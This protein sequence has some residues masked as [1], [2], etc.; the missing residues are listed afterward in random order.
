[1]TFTW[2]GLDG[3]PQTAKATP[4][5]RS[6][7]VSFD[8]WKVNGT[9]VTNFD[10]QL[11]IT[12]D[13]C[14]F[15]LVFTETFV[16]FTYKV[17]DVNHPHASISPHSQDAN[18]NE[19][20]YGFTESFRLE[21]IEKHGAAPTGAIANAKTIRYNEKYNYIYEF[22]NWSKEGTSVIYDTADFTPN[23][24]TEGITDWK[25]SATYICH[26]AA[27][28]A[29]YSITDSGEKLMTF[30]YDEA[31]HQEAYNYSQGESFIFPVNN[32]HYDIN[33]TSIVLPS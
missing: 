2:I 33:A 3:L 15:E 25:T 30:Y 26:V 27:P 9:P 7:Y 31:L 8:K 5:P 29:V 23:L 21:D 1:M 24:T 4:T 18:E 14:P 13:D 28:R 6:E 12:T 20:I 17:V 10:I 16:T 32:S 22:L 11:E 19:E